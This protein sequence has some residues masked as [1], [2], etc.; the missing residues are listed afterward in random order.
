MS[1]N[2]PQIGKAYTWQFKMV[3]DGDGKTPE[4]GL[5]PTL[6]I[7][8]GGAA[9]AGLTGSPAPSEIGDGWY[10][11]VVAA[12]DMVSRVV[13]KATDATSRDTDERIDVPGDWIAR[14]VGKVSANVAT[15]V[16]TFYQPDNVTP[17]LTM[18]KSTVSGT[19][20]AYTPG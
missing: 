3:D 5:T 17:Q 10:E 13:L 18:T 8:K 1:D 19:S 16:T 9:F 12:A 4:T 11:V 6:E 14:Q 7:S 2:Y 20:W 15:G